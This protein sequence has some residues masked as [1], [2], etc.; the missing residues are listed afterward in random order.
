MFFCVQGITH[1]RDSLK[2]QLSVL[3]A[4]GTV[5]GYQEVFNFHS[6]SIE[7]VVMFQ[8]LAISY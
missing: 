3:E 2:L 6:Y 7:I 4:G 8:A 1:E 5:E